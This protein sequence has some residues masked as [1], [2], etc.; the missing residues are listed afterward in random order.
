[1]LRELSEIERFKSRPKSYFPQS[2]EKLV[3]QWQVTLDRSRNQ[4]PDED[5]KKRIKNLMSKL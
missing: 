3:T 4:Q 1:V 5:E 2:L